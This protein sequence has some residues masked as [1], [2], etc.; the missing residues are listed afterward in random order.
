MTKTKAIYRMT[1]F[2]R[3]SLMIALVGLIGLNGFSQQNEKPELN[4]SAF[5]YDGSYVG[6]VVNNLAGGIKTGSAYLGMA[7]IGIGFNTETAKWWKGGELY[8][9][10]GNTHGDTPS[11]DLIG[12]IQVASN[13]EAGDM[14]Y[15]Y[16]FW[17][18]QS[19]GKFDFTIGVQDLNANFVSSENGGLFLNSSFGV[20][21]VMSDNITLPIFPKTALGADISWQ[22]SERLNWRIAIFDGTPNSRNPYNTN[23]II[24]KED[25]YLLVTEFQIAKSLISRLNG[26]Y[27]LGGYYHNHQYSDE[28]PHENGGAY[29]I[30]DQNITNKL[31]LFTQIGIS[32]NNINDHNHFMSLGCNYKNFSE[33]RPDDLFGLALAYFGVDENDIKHE[34]AIEATYKCCINE[35]IYLQPDV[36][37]ILNPAGTGE[38]LDNS[39][40][41]ILRFGV[42]F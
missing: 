4:E 15:L 13:I 18:K 27:K 14:T 10:F 22:A 12:D 40:V 34:T 21:T 28:A 39:L 29:F 7:N 37:Y 20:H 6:D 31:S 32:P 38:K 30:A 3:Q 8:V 42:E 41:A 16:E 17:Y 23:Q 26:T 19:L 1:K 9:N 11:A 33:K 24:G 36:Q 35:N 25:G 5:S 2:I